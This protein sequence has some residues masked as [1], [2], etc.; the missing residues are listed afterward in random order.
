[1]SVSETRPVLV[2][3]ISTFIGFFGVVGV[4][5]S[6]I[7]IALDL[8]RIPR[9][10]ELLILSWS[11]AGAL[12]GICLFRMSSSSRIIFVCWSL[13]LL[14]LYGWFAAQFA[15]PVLMLPSALFTVVLLFLGQ[16]YIHRVTSQ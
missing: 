14:V 11:A 3:L 7:A 6:V 15:E 16:R 5:S 12:A 10:A 9:W 4:F 8:G 13:F 2:L 1:M